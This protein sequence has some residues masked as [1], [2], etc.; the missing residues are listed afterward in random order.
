VSH[1]VVNLERVAGAGL[2]AL[3]ERRR[4]ALH[5]YEALPVP[6]RARTPLRGRRLET[7]PY[8]DPVEPDAAEVPEELRTGPE[9]A[10]HAVLANGSVIS[11]TMRPEWARAGVRLMSLAAASG[12]ATEVLVKHLGALVPQDMDR[13]LAANEA[14]WR[15]G[16]LLHVPR[17]VAIPSPITIVHWVG[18]AARGVFPR[19]LV[20]AEPGSAVHVVESYLGRPDDDHRVLVS[21]LTEVFAQDAASVTV[22]SLQQLPPGAEAFVRRRGRA[23]HDAHLDWATAEFGAALSVAGHHTD[24]AE[25]GASSTSQTVMF[26][27]G[28]QHFD[29]EAEAVHVGTHTVSDMRSRGVMSGRSRGVFTGL[30]QI[31]HGARRADARQREETLMLSRDA[32]ADAIPS[33]IIDDNDV[34]AAHAASAGPVDE[35]ALYYLASRGIPRADGIDMLVRGFLGPVVE[36]IQLPA[37]QER[38]WTAIEAKLRAERSSES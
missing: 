4:Q 24:L 3:A 10:G 21:A 19:T 35:L 28:A 18:E 26:G 14:L 36:R 38:V 6:T 33:L 23:D 12:A 31:V 13:Y 2:A 17:G 27:S 20:V 15:D 22:A 9:S 7:I 11:L 16:V 8:R 1:D 30:S 32:R 29:Y 34:F 25:S 5:A 37:V